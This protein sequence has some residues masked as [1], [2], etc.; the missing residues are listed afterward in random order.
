M[1]FRPNE[2]V[3]DGATPSPG[4]TVDVEKQGPPEVRVEFE[5]EAT[6]IEVRVRW[7]GKLVIDVEADGD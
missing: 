3:L 2:V 1:S 5:S 4:F 6:R 7:D